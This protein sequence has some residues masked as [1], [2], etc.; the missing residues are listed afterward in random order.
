MDVI[1]FI[2]TTDTMRVDLSS[3]NNHIKINSVVIPTDEEL[4]RGFEIINE[5]NGIV[6]GDY[7]AY[8]YVYRKENTYVELT[9]D[10]SDI[11]V[12]PIFIT[13]MYQSAD[14]NGTV[15]DSS[16]TVQTNADKISVKGSTAYPNYNYQFVNWTNSAGEVVCKESKLVPA[17]T[18]ESKDET[19]TAHFEEIP[20]PEKTLDEVKS[21]KD[22]ELN[23][24]YSIS[25]ANGTSATLSDGSTILFGI[26][27]DFINDAMAAF[28]LASALY[29]TDGIAVPFEINK[30]CYQYAPIDVIYIYISMQIYIV[31]MKS[32]RNELLGTVDRT[33][34]KE[35]V[36]KISFN[37]DSLDAQGTEGYQDSMKAGENMV[38][39]LK[40]KFGISSLPTDTPVT[41]TKE[42]SEAETTDDKNK[43]E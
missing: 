31:A 39:V 12:A 43:A 3:S 32:L 36:E 30:V 22:Y 21:E 7:S 15:S 41:D 27:Q 2:G 24:A 6:Q 34:T 26:N 33:E 8:K 42:S 28:N 13:L 5:H 40:T 37:V 18:A 29:G 19:Y 4:A 11:Y 17:I 16:E 14:D 23:N 25:M 20:V 35:A 38:N 9:T 1:R 10:P